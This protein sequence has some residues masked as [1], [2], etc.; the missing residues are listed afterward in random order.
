V[1][2]KRGRQSLDVFFFKCV[3]EKRQARTGSWCLQHA[4]LST[5]KTQRSNI[6][7]CLIRNSYLLNKQMI[8]DNS[9]LGLA[10]TQDERFT[11]FFVIKIKGNDCW[12]L[13]WG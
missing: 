4:C 10:N 11:P 8:I 2:L 3:L 7:S 13:D 6:S 12:H 9:W 5:P 1:T